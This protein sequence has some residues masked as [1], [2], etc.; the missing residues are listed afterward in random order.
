LKLYRDNYQPSALYPKPYATICVWAL[1]ADTEQE[2]QH[3]FKTRERA[4]IDR[5]LGIRLPLISPEEAAARTLSPAEQAI[6]DKLQ[7]KAIVG[8]A[9]Q[10][11][12]RLQ[13]L[14]NDLQ[15]DE[16][17]VVTWTHEAQARRRSYELLAQAFGLTG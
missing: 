4:S 13:T 6:A 2:A 3:Q 9:A 12:A 5:D 17:V 11:Q 1:A 16:L 15:L 8:S 14:A 10:V 7:R